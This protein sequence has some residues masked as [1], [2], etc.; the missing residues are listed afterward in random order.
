M[1]PRIIANVDSLSRVRTLHRQVVDLAA[2]E[3]L[4]GP[5]DLGF[6][7]EPDE[8]PAPVIPVGSAHL[9]QA[10]Q[11]ATAAPTE[12]SAAMI[13]LCALLTANVGFDSAFREHEEPPDA[14]SG[15]SGHDTGDRGSSSRSGERG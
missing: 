7:D 3:P 8:E 11:S 15:R 6:V 12:A 10:L 2:P 5:F 1:G 14:D 13:R 9:S 4:P